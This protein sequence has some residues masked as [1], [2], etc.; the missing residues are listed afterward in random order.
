MGFAVF[1]RGTSVYDS[2]DRQRV[3][4]VDVAVQIDGVT[5]SPGDLVFADE[6]GLVVVPRAIETAAISAAWSKVH[7]ENVTRNAIREGMKATE[8]Y[9]KYGVL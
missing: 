1:A 3:T 4:A 9:K 2:Q 7:A 8:A 6:D 5:F